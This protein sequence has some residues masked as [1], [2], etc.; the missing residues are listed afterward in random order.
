MAALLAM[1]T[2]RRRLTSIR[3]SQQENT[4][5][6]HVLQP[7]QTA[8]QLAKAHFWAMLQDYANLGTAPAA[9]GANISHDHPFL[10]GSGSGLTLN[11]P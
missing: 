1:D 6:S 8:Q 4:A 9:W 3:M 2:G 5:T 11:R 7:V 10:C